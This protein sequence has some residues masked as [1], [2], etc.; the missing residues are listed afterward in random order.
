MGQSPERPL[1]CPSAQPEMPD[2]QILGV[3]RGD[4]EERRIAYLNE[5]VPATA[6]ILAQA[7]P[8]IPGEVFRLAA[9]CETGKCT[10]FDGERCQLAVRI[11]DMLSPV[12]EQL[13]PCTIRKTCRWYAQE[14]RAACLRCPQVVTA[15]N[16]DDEVIRRVAGAPPAA[17]QPAQRT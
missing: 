7:A 6:D 9:R 1:R 17:A 3:V 5:F 13:P 16:E 2:A 15:N 12:T 11:V 8:A 14:G 10:H 4:T